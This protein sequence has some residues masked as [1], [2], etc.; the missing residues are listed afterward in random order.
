V[1][2]DGKEIPEDHRP[3][4]A[5]EGVGGFVFPPTDRLRRHHRQGSDLEIYSKK[6]LTCKIVSRETDPVKSGRRP[7]QSR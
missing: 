2:T 6:K 7:K 5:N 4:G 3:D 1:I